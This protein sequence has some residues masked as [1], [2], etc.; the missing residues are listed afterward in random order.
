V[1]VL[2]T[3]DAET[4]TMGATVELLFS[5]VEGDRHQVFSTPG[6]LG[7]DYD[8]PSDLEYGS[9][10]VNAGMIEAAKRALTR[11]LALH[12][13]DAPLLARMFEHPS[14]TLQLHAFEALVRCSPAPEVA[15]L[16][17]RALEGHLRSTD[18]RVDGETGGVLL[19][20]LSPGGSGSV[21]VRIPRI[22]RELAQAVERH[23][24]HAD[25]DVIF[26]LTR[27]GSA[28]IRALACRWVVA[29]GTPDWAAALRPAVEDES[30]AVVMSALRALLALDATTFAGAL[31]VASRRQW[32]P[33]HYRA[34]VAWLVGQ[35]GRRAW[36]DDGRPAPAARLPP[37]VLRSIAADAMDAACAE[38]RDEAIQE[39]AVPSPLE[40]LVARIDEAE[41]T[42]GEGPLSSGWLHVRARATAGAL[43]RALYRI[44]ARRGVTA[45]AQDLEPLLAPGGSSEALLAAEI[46]PTL[47][48]GEPV[49]QLLT[50]WETTLDEHPWVKV[51]ELCPR[52]LYMLERAPAAYAPLLPRLFVALDEDHEGCLT[53]DG[54]EILERMRGVLVRWGP[55]GAGP[56]L[57]DMDG[58]PHARDALRAKELVLDVYRTC[59]EVQAELRRRAADS[60]EHASA[61]ET[62]DRPTPA[63]ALARLRGHLL[64]EILPVAWGDS[65]VPR[66]G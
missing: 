63:A 2:D 33:E 48:S 60:Q 3:L 10:Q 28:A 20:A 8:D 12:P 27:H 24:T 57:D 36:Y 65:S 4:T 7:S 58:G 54:E 21:D 49:S 66:S 44:L 31:A 41:A 5:L 39:E 11:R 30:A 62:I 6:P 32:S 19:A 61:V 51:H 47:G 64:L 25:R 37:S 14:E 56:L 43:Q 55:S 34:C 23:L 35:S 45:I 29:R 22:G 42:P 13:E 38:V 46:L 9:H 59:A 40:R 26:E 18:T 1:L 53:E 17:V 52:V 15:L 16:G 50:I